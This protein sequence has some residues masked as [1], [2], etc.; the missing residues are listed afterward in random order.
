MAVRDIRTRFVLDGEAKFKSA[1][2]SI[3]T[4]MYLLSAE[5]K[6]STAE[7]DKNADKMKIL[8]AT[9]S[10]LEKKMDVQRQKIAAIKKEHEESAK[11]SG[12]NSNQ[13]KKYAT[14]L[15]YAE[16]TLI[17]MEKELRD[18]Q[19]QMKD[20]EN[21]T[22]ETTD[23]LKKFG[24]EVDDAGE[25][26]KKTDG[27][28]SSF[29]SVMKGAVKAGAIAAA[30]A[31]AAVGTAIGAV[32][33]KSF[34]LAVEFETAFTGVK[35]TVEG[36]DE[37][38]AE[39]E[40]GIRDMAKEVPATAVEISAVAEAAGQLG[41]ET[42]NILEFSR[43]M[44]DLGEATNITATEG[45]ALAAQFANVMQM[46]QSNF[47][48]FGATIVDLGNNSAT[49]EADILSMAQRLAGAG[50]Q[51]GMSEA[52]VLGFAAALSSVGIDAEAGGSALSKV[53]VE[54]QLAA[55]KGGKDL[56]NFASV[57]GVSAQEF[58]QMYKDDAAAA[59][60]VF[61][62][63]LGTLEDRGQDAL[64]VL[65]DMGITE[66]RMRD[67]LLRASNAGDLFSDS[68]DTANTAWGENT[69]LSKEAEQRY[70]TTASQMQILKNTVSDLG[71]SFGQELLPTVNAVVGG[72]SDILSDGIQAGDIQ[73]I[74]DLIT[75]TVLGAVNQ[76]GQYLPEVVTLLSGAIT[77]VINIIVTLLPS[78]LPALITGA[79]QILQ[80]IVTA[81]AENADMLG[82]MVT[83]LTMMIVTFI[84]ENLPLLIE[85]AIDIVL[86]VAQGIGE[87]L[88]ELIPVIVEMVIQ[89]I[90][91]IME[92]I[93]LI[94]EVGL[95]ILI[96]LIQGIAQAIP[97]LIAYLPELIGT[98]VTVLIEN[99]PLIIGAAIEILLALIQG[100]IESIPLLITAMP[101]IID[102][103]VTAF[104]E[105]DWAS[106]GSD[107]LA[108][109]G[110]GI[111]NAVTGVVES[112]KSAAASI[113]GAIG[114]F[115]GIAS[116]SKL[117]MGYG[118]NISEGLA[119]GIAAN[120]DLAQKA[121]DGLI[122]GKLE[123]QLTTELRTDTG[124]VTQTINHT[125]TIRVEGINSDGQLISAVEILIS[126]MRRDSMMAGTI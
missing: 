25:K 113:A 95:E 34:N 38:M 5:L 40:K 91:V 46:D 59:M 45:A 32:T 120:A 119:V 63:E 92:N 89:I 1:M 75:D 31:I 54:M 84:V 55:Q 51:V 49:T 43:V 83:D 56:E 37:Q 60:T 15:A 101:A 67:A 87:A 11:A 3:S 108:G 27:F 125:G 10:T 26:T 6:R 62:E 29:G 104:T 69:A 35:K 48:R 71:I 72:L 98:I 70:A 33:V 66:V 7:F 36:T 110:E 20:L 126:Q 65:D 57:A 81:I 109:V 100:L 111:M 2:T 61:I 76:F 9:S 82:Q 16:T 123:S 77:E 4:E 50:K 115:F 58:A 53:M 117:M 122:P 96:A 90:N 73:A 121:I 88:P 41:I 97:D 107:I 30:T 78:V 114:D 112:A 8:S 94:I 124:S 86:A 99:L 64:V 105:T 13:T 17:D 47:D 74:G 28:L 21:A 116:P 106:Y 12:E 14:S 85:A 118:E 18:N 19:K 42:D 24:K 44:I 52:D 93:G 23:E 68:L 22:D 39:L 102:A 80:G 103:I 79:N